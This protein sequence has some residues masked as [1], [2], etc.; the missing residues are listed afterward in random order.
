[1]NRIL[2]T[3]AT[4]RTASH[5]ARRLLSSGSQVRALVRNPEKAKVMFA[6][7]PTSSLDRLEVIAGDFGDAELLKRGFD[8]VDG[9][10]LALGTSM[11]Q[12]ALEKTLVDAAA[13]AR[14][15]QV[16]RLSVLGAHRD[17]GYEVARRH[18][19][20]DDYVAATGIPHTLLRAAW[21]TSNLL[22]SAGSIANTDHWYGLVPNGRIAMIDTRDVAD[23]AHAVFNNASLQNARYEL[24]G[25]VALT[26][27]EVAALFSVLLGRPISYVPIDEAS[28]RQ[29]F[30]KRGAPAW[31]VDIAV[32]I[33]QAM[34]SGSHATVTPDLGRLLGGPLRPVDDFIRDHHAS[35]VKQ[36]A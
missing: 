31:L 13:R 22:L 26:L 9:V 18:G 27:T 7:L 3:G 12:V 32:G 25:P 5:L 33:E 16:V 6:D 19:E 28:L 10:F 1:M 29:G 35:F 36:V 20:L 24:T 17:G 11:Q 4:G 34:E 2:V 15:R 23:A 21:F 14:V 8:A 30:A